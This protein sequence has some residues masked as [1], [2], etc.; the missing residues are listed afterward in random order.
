MELHW[1]WWFCLM[2]RCA[3]AACAQDIFFSQD[4]PHPIPDCAAP[5]T[6]LLTDH[7]PFLSALWYPMTRNHT[8][9]RKLLFT[10]DT[11]MVL[12]IHLITQRHHAAWNANPQK[13]SAAMGLTGYQGRPPISPTCLQVFPFASPGR[14][15]PYSHICSEV[16]LL[17]VGGGPIP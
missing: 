15:F 16:P 6:Q 14:P 11:E 17:C 4:F 10:P 5:S 8:L 2:S 13:E 7:T 12:C 9:S 1:N 3:T